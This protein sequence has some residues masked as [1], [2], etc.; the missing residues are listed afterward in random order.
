MDLTLLGQGPAKRATSVSGSSAAVGRGQSG[1]F[2]SGST[3]SFGGNQSRGRFRRFSPRGQR[4][5]QHKRWWLSHT[6]SR[7]DSRLG[8]LLGSLEVEV[9]LARAELLVVRLI[10]SGS[11]DLLLAIGVVFRIIW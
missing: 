4:S 10:S 11:S 6:V 7:P 5:G 8:N 3:A 2:S 9:V 1:G